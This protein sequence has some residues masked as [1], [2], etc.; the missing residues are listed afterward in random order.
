MS[1]NNVNETLP[2]FKG[3]RGR[4][5][6]VPDAVFVDMVRS[7]SS[8]DDVINALVVFGKT[9]EGE[10]QNKF[11]TWLSNKS[12]KS[13]RLYI[14]MRAS[15]LRRKN[16]ILT[17]SRTDA[18]KNTFKPGPKVNAQNVTETAEVLSDEDIIP[19]S[20]VAVSE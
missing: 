2:T 9:L 4:K 8:I 19:E 6:L 3:K 5:S 15:N 10:E 17:N 14:S 12:E 18:E 20:D 1:E 7:A 13:L 16:V 11:T